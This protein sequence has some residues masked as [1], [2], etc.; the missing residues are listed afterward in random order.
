MHLPNRH[1]A[2]VPEEKIT[3]YLLDMN[4]PDGWGKAQEFRRRG[5]NESNTEL[6]IRDLVAVAQT[7]PVSNIVHTLHGSNYVIYGT[8][9]PP[10]G[11]A[12]LVLTVWFIAHGE[13]I[14]RLATAY[15]REPERG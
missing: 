11:G 5:Y 15:P 12:L 14:P 7:E 10:R 8:I 9:Q 3:R 2:F 13:C 6:F 1:L 4:H